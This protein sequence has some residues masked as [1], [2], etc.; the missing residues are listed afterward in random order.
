MPMPPSR[1][2][3]SPRARRSASIRR[4]GAATM[5]DGLRPIQAVHTGLVIRFLENVTADNPAPRSSRSSRSTRS[6]TF[7]HCEGDPGAIEAARELLEMAEHEEPV[8]AAMFA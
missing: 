4:L 1:P 6:V 2:P 3:A 7:R 5:Q 8:A